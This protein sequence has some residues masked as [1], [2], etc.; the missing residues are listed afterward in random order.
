[1]NKQLV[2]ILT[3]VLVVCGILA[4]I[5]L[6][7]I[8]SFSHIKQTPSITPVPTIISYLDIII[9]TTTPIPTNTP[10]PTKIPTPTIQVYSYGQLEEMFTTYSNEFSVSRDKLWKIAVCESHLNPNSVNGQYVGMFQFSP[11]TWTTL[12][13]QL[14]LP[15][16]V[17][18]RTD[19]KEAIRTAAFKLSVG[20]LGAWPECGKL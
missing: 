9:I 11:Y 16:N 17:N 10:K 5:N 4:T 20:G 3:C 19:A 15:D 2:F 12:R 7:Q 14:N 1:M 18:L 6:K 8:T 13:R